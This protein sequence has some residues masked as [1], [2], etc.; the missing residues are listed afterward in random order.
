MSIFGRLASAVGLRRAAPSVDAPLA[1]PSP[2]EPSEPP[3][4]RAEEQEIIRSLATGEFFDRYPAA[5]AAIAK[6]GGNVPKMPPTP[7]TE[8]V[9]ASGLGVYAG[10]LPGNETSA[11]LSGAARWK[12]YE[13]WKR[14]VAPVGQT[15]REHLLLSGAPAWTVKP[16]VADGED[17]ATPEDEERAAWL[18]RQL[19][20]LATE[21]ERVVMEHAMALIDGARIGVWTAKLMPAGDLGA[22]GLADVM[23][24][25]LSTIERWDVDT[26][27][28]RLRGVVQRDPDSQA[29]IPIAR[30][31]MI[32]SRDLPT[33]T[34][35]A[36]DGVMR[37]LADTIRR[38]QKLEELLDKGFESDVNGIPVVYAPILEKMAQIGK[39]LP[40]GTTYTRARFNEDMKDAVTF[41]SAA[42]R[43]NAGI[44]LDSSTV[45]NPDGTPS[46]VR[47]FHAEVLTA[48]STAHAELRGRIKDL[49]WDILAMLSSEQKAMGRDGGTQALHQSKEAGRLRVVSSFLNGFAKTAKRDLVR[50][51]WILNGFDPTSPAD[52][53]NLPTLDWNALEFVDTGAVVQSVS[54][55]LTAAG[56]VEPERVLKIVNA[57]LGNYG[58]PALEEMDPADAAL[59]REAALG[60]AGARDGRRDPADPMPVDDLEDDEEDPPPAPAP[61]RGK[62]KG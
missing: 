11:D 13:S 49:A 32:Y 42:K 47:R 17:E 26:A 25:P 24:I 50:P 52:P 40:D 1:L 19:D 59:A 37:F 45:P 55:L 34:H 61:R 62:A 6:A 33:T 29:E 38:M 51:L 48:A 18:Q 2:T 53:Q 9:G 21:W 5:A 22:F 8:P 54:A 58:L 57:I 10:Y 41:V 20:N 4:S 35:P 14:T 56:I 23:T 3:L 36:G 12:N 15:I 46:T 27:T 60:R 7:V 43:K 39:A 16:F 44:I 31:R 30:E 28:G